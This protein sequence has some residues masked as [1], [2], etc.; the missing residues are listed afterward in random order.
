MF[1]QKASWKKLP[2]FKSSPK[3]KYLC[4]ENKTWS[5]PMLDTYKQ[6]EKLQVAAIFRDIAIK[7][8]VMVHFCERKYIVLQLY[9]A[10]K[11]ASLKVV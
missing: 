10:K 3:K 9:S 1:L 11:C 6:I 7:T 5:E 8:L 2:N 4:W